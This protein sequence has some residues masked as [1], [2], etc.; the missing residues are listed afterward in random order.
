MDL[1]ARDASLYFLISVSGNSEELARETLRRIDDPEVLK[2]A[3]QVRIKRLSHQLNAA[4]VPQAKIDS[5]EKRYA[6]IMKTC[7]KRWAKKQKKLKVEAEQE[8]E[9]QRLHG[10]AGQCIQFVDKNKK[11][12]ILD[13]GSTPFLRW[14]A[15]IYEDSRFSINFYRRES[16]ASNGYEWVQVKVGH[17]V[18]FEI[19]GPSMGTTNQK[20]KKY[21]PG[22]WENR[23]K[24]LPTE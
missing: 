22:S 14:L 13:R 3:I 2:L 18:V 12:K 20:L 21:I 5:I 9:R 7:K 6:G 4:G 16:A 1:S 11:S 15:M 19:E 10:L 23:I 8:K 24:N 17:K